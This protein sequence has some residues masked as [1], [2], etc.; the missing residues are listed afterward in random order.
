MVKHFLLAALVL[1]ACGQP[2]SEVH[3]TGTHILHM[4]DVE[5]RPMQLFDAEVQIHANIANKKM[6]EHKAKL[7]REREQRRARERTERRQATQP[8]GDIW[9]RL[10]LCESGG[11]QRATSP[12]GR[13][14]GYF[15]FVMST[16]R[17]Y[18]G[19]G[20]PRDHSYT[21]QLAVA[22]RVQRGQSWAA[23]PVCSRKIGVR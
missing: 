13:Y 12:S 8:R 5:P 7:E 2:S 18:G 6:A 4:P 16:W 19:T 9:W 20:D 1:T 11:R 3:Y 14:L 17:A 23:W 15:Q 22:K 10:A 21:E